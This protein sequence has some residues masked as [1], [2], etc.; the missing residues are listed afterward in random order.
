VIPYDDYDDAI[1]I[2]NDSQY[3]LS[4]AVYSADRE[5]GERIARRMRT[6]QVFVNSAGVCV[7]QPYGGYKQSGIGREGGAEGIEMYL[8]T[9]V[10]RGV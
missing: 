8:E 4:G 6:G 3:G 2:A 7:T 10:L 5:L 9:K 1:R